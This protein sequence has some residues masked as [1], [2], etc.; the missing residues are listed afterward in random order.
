MFLEPQA[1]L[2]TDCMSCM[3]PTGTRYP[4]AESHGRTSYKQGEAQL[5]QIL[6]AGA[7]TFVCVQ[8]R[9]GAQNSKHLLMCMQTPT[10]RLRFAHL[11][12]LSARHA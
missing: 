11:A 2:L 10:D 6:E 9:L 4:Y 1:A 7:T 5:A 12:Q 8:V 3:E